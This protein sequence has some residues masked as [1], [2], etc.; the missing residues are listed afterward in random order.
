M[1]YDQ[2]QTCLD[3]SFRTVDRI[4]AG[5]QLSAA[6]TAHV[7]ALY[8]GEVSFTDREIGRLLEGMKSPGF[9]D[10]TMV[11]VTADHGQSLND[12]GKWFHPGILYDSV[13]RIPLVISYPPIAP[14]GLAV[15]AVAR[16]VDIMPTI[17][18]LVGVPSPKRAE[19]KSLWPIMLGREKGDERVAFTEGTDGRLTAVVTREW[20]LIRNNVTGEFELYNLK[21]DPG[22]LKNLALANPQQVSKLDQRLKV[23]MDSHGISRQK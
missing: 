7:V 20:K 16:S 15:D 2:C 13:V 23:W 14:A 5:E 18:D 6:D 9:L 22:E 1:M 3:G 12:N 21:S 8:N 19:G 17:L 11:I 10:N 4:G